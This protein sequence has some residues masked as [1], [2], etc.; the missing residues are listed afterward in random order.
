MKINKK[1]G[2]Q[3]LNLEYLHRDLRNSFKEDLKM[4]SRLKLQLFRHLFHEENPSSEE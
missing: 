3:A 1:A 4:A 2:E